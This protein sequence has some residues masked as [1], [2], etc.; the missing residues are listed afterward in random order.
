MGRQLEVLTHTKRRN[1]QICRRYF[2]NKHIHHLSPRRQ[3]GGRRRGTIFAQL[4]AACQETF[5][6]CPRHKPP[7]GLEDLIYQGA[8]QFYDHIR[9]DTNLDPGDYEELEVEEVKVRVMARA[10]VNEYGIDPRREVEFYLPLR[11]PRTGRTSRAFKLGG[12]IDGVVVLAENHAAVIEDKFVGSIQK[13]MIERLALDSQS[14]EYVDAFMSKGWTADIWY[15]HT[16]FPGINPKPGREYKT[17]PDYPGETLEEFEER[18]WEDV[19]EERPE[20]YFDQQIVSFP[21]SHMDD[22]RRGRW[23]LAQ[24]ILAARRHVGKEREAEFFE[25]NDSRCWEYGGCEFIPLCTNMDGAR[26]LYIVEEDNPELMEGGVTE[27]YGDQA[28]D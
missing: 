17:K 19:T 28:K 2:L 1:F 4:I 7:G 3:R 23:G 21:T 18:L 12:K 11:N 14:T 16:R 27:T 25:K 24:Q 20:F 13:P 9:E 5:G 26:D 10:Y 15:R 22:Y 6:P 8:I